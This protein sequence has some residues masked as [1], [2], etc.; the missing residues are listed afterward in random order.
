MTTITEPVSKD[1]FIPN[2][3]K[4]NPRDLN[5]MG[6]F[7]DWIRD[8]ENYGSFYKVYVYALTIF[9]SMLMVISIVLSPLFIYGFKEYI[10]Q[11]ERARFDKEFDSLHQMAT[12]HTWQ[13]F[14]QGRLDP[15]K[16]V[17]AS[18]SRSER[19]H[20]I[21]DLELKKEDAK[22]IKDIDLLRMA[23]KKYPDYISLYKPTFIAVP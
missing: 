5:W 9:T 1:S 3:P 7:V 11:C 15:L 13:L 21:K 10:R 18:L 4:M 20:I 19:D 17:D 14:L 6:R 16:N 22:K 23:A 2:L 12:E 8:A